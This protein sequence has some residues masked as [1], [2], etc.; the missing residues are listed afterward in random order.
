M[1]KAEF[2]CDECQTIV[3]YGSWWQQD[4]LVMIKD[5]MKSIINR[6]LSSKADTLLIPGSNTDTLVLHNERGKYYLCKPHSV[7][8]PLLDHF[9]DWKMEDLC[10]QKQ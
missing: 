5:T 1:F 8:K 6:P 9:P 4:S 10:L 2:G 3:M 7:L